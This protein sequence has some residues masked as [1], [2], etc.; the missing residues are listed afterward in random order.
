MFWVWRGGNHTNEHL[1]MKKEGMV[2]QRRAVR[3]TPQLLTMDLLDRLRSTPRGPAGELLCAEVQ[4][5]GR[6]EARPR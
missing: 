3:E 1:V 5:L 6:V 2:V 4:E